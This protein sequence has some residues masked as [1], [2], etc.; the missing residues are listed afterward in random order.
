MPEGP[1]VRIITEWLRPRLINKYLFAVFYDNV[2][3]YRNKGI[4]HYDE[5]YKSLPLKIINISCKGKVIIFS[6]DQGIYL[7]SQ[8]GM[9]G[10]WQKESSKHTNLWIKYGSLLS[11][12][13]R[14][15]ETLYFDDTRHHGHFDI[16]M[17]RFQL[18]QHKLSNFGVDLLAISLGS[19]DNDINQQY[20]IEEALDK[21]E[22][23]LTS[24]RIQDKEIWNFLLQDQQR[25]CGIGNYLQAEILYMSR[26]HPL[27]KLKDLSKEDRIR[28]L[29]QAIN[30]IYEAYTYGG[31][32]INDFWDPEGRKGV[33]PCRIYQKDKDPEGRTIYTIKSNK[34]DK[35]K[36][37]TLH[38][39]PEV[40][41]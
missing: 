25:F 3:K 18:Q 8:M 35:T 33:Y 16:Y 20:T 26:I 31:L 19:F 12:D 22:R 38:F 29:Y 32:T 23:E 10:R 13:V 5:L 37:R 4:D 1:E 30:S 9:S 7:T 14:L 24:S 6:L 40:Q 41:I 17:N 27:R 28:L 11:N 2:S 21:W 39:V 34:N 15:T 36:G